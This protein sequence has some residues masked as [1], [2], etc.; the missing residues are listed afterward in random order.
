MSTLSVFRKS[1]DYKA[2]VL[3]KATPEWNTPTMLLRCVEE[4]GKEMTL[5]MSN[6][7]YES[8]IDIQEQRVYVFKVPGA[9]VKKN[10]SANRTGAA[11]DVEVKMT[12]PVKYSLAA[13]SFPTKVQYELTGFMDLA[14]AEPGTW[15][16][17]YGQVVQVGDKQERSDKNNKTLLSKEVVLRS[18]DFHETLDLLGAH[19]ELKV[20][21]GNRLV[22]KGVK[23][24]EWNHV[25]KL[26]TSFLTY[27]E[28]D[29]P[30]NK[31]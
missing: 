9:C 30:A 14:Q 23:I 7:A 27:V 8:C 18:G 19:S 12:Y 26:S 22:A 31:T 13:T 29:P 16:D 4:D 1:N 25:R 5:T 11:G 24:N 28:I 17:I 2:K 6:K 3:V 15:H 21:V 10:T 20:L